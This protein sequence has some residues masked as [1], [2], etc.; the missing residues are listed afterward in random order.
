MTVSRLDR[1]RLDK[2]AVDEDFGLRRGKE[3]D[4]LAFDSIAGPASPR[5]TCGSFGFVAATNHTLRCLRYRTTAS[6]C[7]RNLAA[8]SRSAHR[9]VPRVRGPDANHVQDDGG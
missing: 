1:I 6:P 3:G 5:L 4:W 7:S 9:T 2:A 8:R